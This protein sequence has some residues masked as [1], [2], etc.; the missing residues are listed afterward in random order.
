[1]RIHYSTDGEGLL[2]GY[3]LNV[4]ARRLDENT[5]KCS[6]TTTF[7]RSPELNTVRHGYVMQNDCLIPTLT[8]RETLQYSAD[9][10]LRDSV[11]KKERRKIVEET[12]LELGLKECASTRIGA[13]TA[14]GCSGGA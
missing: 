10:R 2:T 1:M 5:L 12:I 8:V 4:L 6:G 14:K 7:N 13:S 11:D 3:R 9:L